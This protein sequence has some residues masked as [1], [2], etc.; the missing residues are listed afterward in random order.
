MINGNCDSDIGVAP[1]Q[2]DGR[3]FA[4]VTW[5][6]LPGRRAGRGRGGGGGRVVAQHVARG[7]D[8]VGQVPPSNP[9]A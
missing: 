6:T 8:R 7:C 2:F 5:I 4:K 1:R 9:I 3:Q